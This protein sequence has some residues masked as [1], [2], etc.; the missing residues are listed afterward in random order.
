MLIK[1]KEM[2]W[3]MKPEPVQGT[4]RDVQV[5][6]F[7]SSWNPTHSQALQAHDGL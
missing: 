7:T 5:S 2:I 1:E 6:H 3:T 4:S